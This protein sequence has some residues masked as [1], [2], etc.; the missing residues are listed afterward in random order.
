M[1]N[2]LLKG[3]KTNNRAFLN[4]IGQRPLASEHVGPTNDRG[5][6]EALRDDRTGTAKANEPS[7]LAR[8]FGK[9]PTPEHFV[10]GAER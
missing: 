7:V 4:Y 2:N 10:T 8:S 1:R 6:M 3:I 5:L 9:L